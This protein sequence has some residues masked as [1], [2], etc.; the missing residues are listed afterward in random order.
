MKRLFQLIMIVAFL[1]VLFAC[2]QNLVFE[3]YQN[4]SDQKWYKDSVLVFNVAIEDTTQNNNF[5][6]NVR[7]DVDYQYSNLWLFLSIE[8]PDGKILDDKFEV[9][10]ADPSGQ[11]LGNG[12]G[13]LKTREAVYRRNIFFPVSGE[14]KIRIQQGMR[15]DYLKGISDIGV[16]IE[17]VE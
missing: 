15:E 4:I 13:G 7:N 11:W 3:Q 9:A 17:A 1:P 14:Y 5:I 2:R 12:F 16:R 8:Q 10:L 6:I